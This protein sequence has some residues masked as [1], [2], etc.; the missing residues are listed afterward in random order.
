MGDGHFGYNVTFGGRK[1]IVATRKWG[2]PV[3]TRTLVCLILI[4]LLCHCIIK[5]KII[6]KRNSSNVYQ[7]LELKVPSCWICNISNL[8]HV[9][10]HVIEWEDA[11]VLTSTAAGYW[12]GGISR[13][14]DTVFSK[15]GFS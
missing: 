5:T 13:W 3:P 15:N 11:Y 1:C 6:I 12:G 10:L 8:A 14:F 9:L 4:I 2:S 7:K